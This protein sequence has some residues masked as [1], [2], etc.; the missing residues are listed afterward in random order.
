[1]A[2][3]DFFADIDPLSEVRDTVPLIPTKAMPV[4]KEPTMLDD[5]FVDRK[6]SKDTVNVE[7]MKEDMRLMYRM[8]EGTRDDM[9]QKEMQRDREYA[10]LRQEMRDRDHT[11]ERDMLTLMEKLSDL[12]LTLTAQK[13][14]TKDRI[15]SADSQKL[16]LDR[17]IKK[18]P[19]EEAVLCPIEVKNTEK[20]KETVEPSKKSGFITKPATFD[21]NTSW[22]DY[23]SHFHMCSE[24]N[25]W[26]VKQKGLYLGVSLRGLA[27]GVLG[28]LPVEDQKDFEVLS[29]AL[30]D[31][32]SPESQTELYRAQLK[33]RE[34][35]HGENVAEFGTRIL[36]LTTLSYPKANPSLIK[37]LAMGFFIDAISDAEM[38]LKIQQTRPKDLNEAVKVAVELEAFDRAERQRR[39]QKYARQ[40]D[41]QTEGNSELRQLVELMNED[42]K[43]DKSNLRELI[44]FLKQNQKEANYDTRNRIPQSKTDMNSKPKKRCYI[45]GDEK[46]LANTCPKKP[47]CYA[48]HET[49]HK[50][51]DCPKSK[52]EAD[53]SKPNVQA[54][55]P[56]DRETI[57][58]VGHTCEHPI[59]KMD[60][61]MYCCGVLHGV[62]MTALIDSGAT[63][64]MISDTVYNKLPQHK[65]PL[66]KPVECRMVAANGK[67]VT[68]IGLA[69]FTLS[70]RGKLFHL[71]AIVAKINTEVVIG[72]DF[73]QKFSCRLD[74][75]DCTL[76]TEDTV[77]NCFMKTKQS[78]KTTFARVEEESEM[79]IPSLKDA[80]LADTEI[81]LVCSWVEK[82]ERPKWTTVSE[83]SN[84]VKSYW[85]Q[86]Q[87]LCIHDNLL[88]RIW[89]EG[90]KPEKYQIIVPRD[91]RKTVLQHCHDSI[92][93]GHFG[94]RKTLEK[95]R[96][97]YYW[98]GLYA[99]VEQYVQSCDICLRGKQAHE[100]TREHIQTEMRRQK[101]YHDNKLFWEKFSEGDEVYVFFRRNY[102]GRSPK[103]TYYWQGPYVVLEKYSDLT[104]KVKH[105]MTGYQKMVHVDR[106]KRKYSRDETVEAIRESIEREV[107]T[108][109]TVEPST[110]LEE[111]EEICGEI[112]YDAEEEKKA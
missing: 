101:R 29:K 43:K 100:I 12:Q 88:C 107:Q 32:F 86:F 105:M 82:E 50:S 99:Y 79:E 58:R 44:D 15:S 76:N 71:P 74:L 83:M 17:S 109:E 41:V 11:R 28:N 90:K 33:E 57:K 106:M 30:S 92:V 27:Q 54:E 63:A 87:R 55:Q 70:F 65:R 81:K 64:T 104:Y 98:A 77:I 40:T 73:M 34:W 36:R 20:K 78:V 23:R 38:R 14:V 22:I 45:C 103:F 66:L 1:M 19:I 49:G 26:T 72:L 5:L 84:R 42:R 91:L 37:S 4:H 39:G 8:I 47:K 46:H 108:E 80:Q 111:T 110:D 18:E 67:D 96:Q 75:K 89:Y 52:R 93:G 6:M 31:R 62:G 59:D 85:S 2:H 7:Q 94:M 9:R 24:L 102:V 68:T 61:G 13:E 3:K 112:F 97:K 48:C 60:S 25:N 21:G 16:D 35:K 10:E 51:I 53:L 95:V 69:E 56:T